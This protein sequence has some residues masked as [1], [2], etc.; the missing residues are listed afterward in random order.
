MITIELNNYKSKLV[1]PIKKLMAIKQAFAL[2]NPNAYFIRRLG[3]VEPGW[4]GKIHYITDSYYFKTG[5]L[6]Q[7]YKY[8]TEEL[9][10]KVKVVDLRKDMTAGIEVK[11]PKTI[12]GLSERETQYKAIKSIVENKVGDIKFPIGVIDAATNSGKT[13]IMVG[14]YL[15]YKGKVPALVLLKDGDLFEQFLTEIPLLVGDDFGYVRGKNSKWG[16]FTI[17]MVQTLSR[18]IHKYRQEIMKKGIILV[19][20]ADEGESKMYRTVLQYC[21]NSIVRVGLSGT[22]FMSNLAK[23]RPKN[24]NLHSFFGET[25]FKVTK[26]ENVEL[27]YS[28]ELVI[29]MCKGNTNPH[30]YGGKDY[31][32]CY[33]KVIVYGDELREKALKRIRVNLLLKRVP[34]LIICK[35]HN[36][37]DLMYKAINNRFGKK[38]KVAMVHHKTKDRSKIIQDFREGNYDILVT[39]YIVKRGKNFPKTRY[40]CNLSAGDSIETVSQLMGRLERVYKGKDKA[41]FD[42]FYHLGKYLE[43]HSKNRLRQYKKEGF[44]V[45][46]EK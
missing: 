27:G 4:D 41:Y 32:E 34:M 23:H 20:E 37:V 3:K 14:I 2:R 22:I 38:Y 11:V 16:K 44:K 46:I 18:D 25:V 40:L 10:E 8:I 9:G 6:P 31:K 39:T 43:K 30:I 35:Y 1:G 29:R 28:T 12:K 21:N 15:A 19:D 13:A 5:L 42:D 17:A 33:D 7:I 24:Q 36:H 45:I 26:K